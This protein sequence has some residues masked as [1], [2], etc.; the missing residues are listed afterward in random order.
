M[1][2]PNDSPHRQNG[3]V[4]RINRKIEKMLSDT[5]W[6]SNLD[7]P[8][9]DRLHDWA[10]STLAAHSMVAHTMT[11]VDACDYLEEKVTHVQNVLSMIN[12]VVG[13]RVKNISPS[14]KELRFNLHI[15]LS[16]MRLLTNKRTNPYQVK[17]AIR[18]AQSFATMSLDQLFAEVFALIEN[19]RGITLT[20]ELV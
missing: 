3:G 18:V 2:R 5:D 8:D 13:K 14:E 17:R 9:A 20:A 10:L 7:S 16:N 12:E 11:S 19:T 6:N 15:I 4:G 1:I